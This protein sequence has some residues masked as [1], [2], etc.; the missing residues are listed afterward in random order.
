[1]AAQLEEALAESSQLVQSS[2]GVFEVED[3]GTLVF[4][5]RQLGRFPADDEVLSILRAVDAGV[6]LD[7]AKRQAAENVPEPISFMNWLS[8]F[9]KRTQAR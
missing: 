5:K 4:S 3:R 7:E 1:L 9:F 6:S 2:G 8:G